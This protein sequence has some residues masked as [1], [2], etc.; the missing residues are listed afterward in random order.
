MPGAVSSSA[1]MS[2]IAR[3]GALRA[4]WLPALALVVICAGFYND[5]RMAILG[6]MLLFIIYPMI[7]SFTIVR[8]ATLP[9]LAERTLAN[10][11]ALIDG[12]LHISSV[13]TDEESGQENVRHLGTFDI[14]GVTHSGIYIIFTTGKGLADIVIAPADDID[15]RALL[16]IESR[17]EDSNF[18]AHDD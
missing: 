15:S 14:C 12:H 6:L 18:I 10:R 5:I 11:F 17:L 16:E 7:M 3:R 2:A 13:E 8:Y 9:S 4:W 1:Y